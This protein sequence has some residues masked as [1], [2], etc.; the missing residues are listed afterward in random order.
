MGWTTIRAAVGSG[1]GRRRGL[2]SATKDEGVTAMKM[3]W[4]AR[5]SIVGAL[6]LFVATLVA[7]VALAWPAASRGSAGATT[8]EQ[9]GGP[10]D[11]QP[12]SQADRMLGTGESLVIVV[13][14]R[15]DDEGE[16]ARA[17]A[18]LSFG[19]LQGFYVDRAANYRLLGYYEQVSPDRQVV[20]CGALEGP[21]GF[22]CRDVPGVWLSQPEVRLVYHP[23]DRPTPIR[24]PEPCGVVGAPPCLAGRLAHVLATA[25]NHDL[26]AGVLLLSAFRTKAGAAAFMDLARSAGA[27]ELVALRVVKLGGPYVGLGQEAHPDG[28]GPLLGPLPD[29]DVYQE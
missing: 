18:G 24:D 4:A 5:F 16:A 6:S 1:H 27:T 14:G 21:S 26:G 8:N 28:S 7:A 9:A 25:T 2:S 23:L 13:N 11:A 3:P 15:F 12:G 19:E 20:D 22:E 10:A 29:P 17:S